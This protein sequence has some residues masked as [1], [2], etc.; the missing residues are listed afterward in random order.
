ML[1]QGCTYL[2]LTTE[3]SKN[4]HITIVLNPEYPRQSSQIL[5][6]LVSEEGLVIGMM[7]DSRKVLPKTFTKTLHIV[8]CRRK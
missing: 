7:E 3:T 5:E 8:V 4:L 6:I 2:I 1:T